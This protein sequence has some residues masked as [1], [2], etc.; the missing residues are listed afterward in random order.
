MDKARGSRGHSLYHVILMPE[1]NLL[2]AFKKN[3]KKEVFGDRTL[4]MTKKVK[5]W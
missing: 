4:G 2:F 3:L 5:R 1:K